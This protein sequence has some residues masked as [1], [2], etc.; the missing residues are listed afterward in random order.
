VTGRAI[1]P[2]PLDH[3]PTVMNTMTRLARKGLIVAGRWG[4]AG[5]SITTP[6]WI[7]WRSITVSLEARPLGLVAYQHGQNQQLPSSVTV[8]GKGSKTRVALPQSAIWRELLRFRQHTG[9]DVSLVPSRYLRARPTDSPV[10]LPGGMN[11]EITPA[12]KQRAS[13]HGPAGAGPSPLF[14]PCARDYRRVVAQSVTP[15]MSV[16][17]SLHE[18]PRCGL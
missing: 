15:S 14:R 6:L 11:S 3:V 18:A 17:A 12:G 5:H 8:F 4:P 16:R 9:L 13:R 2:Q 1:W 7:V 10:E